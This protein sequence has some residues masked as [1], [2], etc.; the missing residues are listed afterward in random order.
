LWVRVAAG[1][2]KCR[3]R[4]A[5]RMLFITVIVLIRR[6]CWMLQL[7]VLLPA[8]I[9]RSAKLQLNHSSWCL[10]YAH[11]SHSNLVHHLGH[12][13]GLVITCP[14]A[15]DAPALTRYLLQVLLDCADDQSV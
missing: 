3:H 6:S 4:D 11:H 5:E 1:I 8:G 12:V 13:C 9:N 15:F 7:C 10:D 2:L 14:T